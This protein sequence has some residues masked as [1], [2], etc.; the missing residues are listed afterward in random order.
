MRRRSSWFMPLALL[1]F[2]CALAACGPGDGPGG[3]DADAAPDSTT[4]AE[5]SVPVEVQAV[6]R[7]PI[8]AVIRATS[9]LEAEERVIVSAEAARRVV[10]ILAEEGDQVAKGAL[11]L[12]LQDE[13]QESM[14]AKA[15]TALETAR[16]EWER[17]QRLYDRELTT[18]KAYN[19]ALANFEQRQIELQDAERELSYTRVRATIAG[20]VTQRFVK[21]GDQVSPGQQ[22]FELIDFRSLQALVY[23][24]E[25]EL[26]RLEPGQPVR[27]RA[28]AIREEPYM[29][30]LQR[31]SPIVD[32]RTGTVKATVDVGGQ[33]GLRPGLYVDVELITEVREDALLVPKRALVYEDDRMTAYRVRS[34]VVERVP[35]VPAMSNDA[36]VL[37]AG[38]IAEGDTLVTAGQAG[39]KS[40]ARVEIVT[41]ETGAR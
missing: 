3:K 36:F 9:T 17:Q 6:A 37:P 5:A 38:G 4:A 30:T 10:E 13:E 41:R 24:P 27:V 32:A 23:V 35:I 12:R 7:G 40:G 25:K 11:M 2:V 20:T 28:P 1:T 8:E 29:A 15:R 18:E 19:D 33:P 39:L 31:V 16:R 26:T 22:L 34:G 14:L 21:L